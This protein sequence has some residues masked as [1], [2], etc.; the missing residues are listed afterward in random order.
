MYAP[1]EVHA[2]V[3]D[4]HDRRRAAEAGR[5]TTITV[6]STG[7]VEVKPG[8]GVVRPGAPGTSDRG[9]AVVPTPPGAPVTA[10]PVS[11]APE[12]RHSPIDDLD[13]EDF[14]RDLEEADRVLRERRD[15][16]AVPP[17]PPFDDDRYG[18]PY[19]YRPGAPA[20][21]YP[22]L[23]PPG[24]PGRRYPSPP[25]VAPGAPAGV[26]GRA[27]RLGAVV[28]PGA[29]APAP[30]ERGPAGPE[31]G[32]RL[33]RGIL[34]AADTVAKRK[35]K[36]EQGVGLGK[37][38]KQWRLKKAANKLADL[39]VEE[40]GDD[41]ADLAEAEQLVER[42]VARQ[43]IRMAPE[44]VQGVVSW[45]G[46]GVNK[47]VETLAK[48]KKI[49]GIVGGVLA[50]VAG[51]GIAAGVA[52]G[53]GLAMLYAGGAG[54]VAGG[55]KAGLLAFAREKFK[56][57]RDNVRKN[58]E[59]RY[60]PDTG[61]KVSGRYDPNKPENWGAWYASSRDYRDKKGR[62]VRNKTARA[63]GKGAVFGAL[64]AMSGWGFANIGGGEDVAPSPDDAPDA[65]GGTDRPPT[66][67]PEQ[68][69]SGIEDMIDNNPD[70]IDDVPGLEE[71]DLYTTE[72]TSEAA[73][74][75]YPGEHP[76]N[77]YQNGANL[78]NGQTLDGFM[79]AWSEW[80]KVDGIDLDAW[81]DV[82]FD[83]GH[84]HTTGDLWGA[85]VKADDLYA[86]DSDG[87]IF[88][89]DG[90]LSSSEHGMLVDLTNTKGTDFLHGNEALADYLADHVD[91]S[92]PAEVADA[93]ALPHA[94]QLADNVVRGLQNVDLAADGPQVM[95]TE[96][97]A[98]VNENSAQLAALDSTEFVLSM[99]NQ[100]AL[101]I[102]DFVDDHSHFWAQADWIFYLLDRAYIEAREA[103]LA[104]KAKARKK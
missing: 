4:F 57:T 25:P 50:I 31:G 94:E 16:G 56:V 54:A 14:L 76:W 89:F 101:E 52:A 82:E 67:T 38:F 91:T 21:P 35:M 19:P 12:R 49:V 40:Y 69:E 72:E 6:D 23:P 2:S 18:D 34:D 53:A 60:D 78:N 10:P 28:A 26:A 63:A 29:P 102:A 95:Q 66:V 68:I 27:H 15:R 48:H 20:V 55:I 86:V 71:Y 80:R 65:P 84:Y 87:D 104:K 33:K 44:R 42:R 100:V 61:K 75:G 46:M 30:G 90:Q 22:V 93:L 88:H 58:V 70:K 36:L 81:G 24:G 74:E 99:A 1:P 7:D 77:A 73:A 97:S 39:V 92:D 43:R 13:D 79:D 83:D 45:V 5:P 17:I 103:E 98:Y 96:L 37:R 51:G 11:P 85:E 62:L 47:V 41:P 8:T 3:R 64:V 59:V 32:L 9:R